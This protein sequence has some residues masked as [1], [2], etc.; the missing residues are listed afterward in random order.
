MAKKV[1]AFLRNTFFGAN[2]LKLE[3]K[4]SSSAMQILNNTLTILLLVLICAR[5]Y[6]GHAVADRI[7][8]KHSNLAGCCGYRFCFADSCG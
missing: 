6:V 7:I 2:G 3:S 8:K 1:A 4:L 5:V